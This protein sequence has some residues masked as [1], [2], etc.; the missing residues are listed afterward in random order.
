MQSRDFK[1]PISVDYLLNHCINFT[2]KYYCVL[3]HDACNLGLH[4]ALVSRMAPISCFY[5]GVYVIVMYMYE[6]RAL[7]LR[8]RQS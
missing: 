5:A 6:G 4:F 8:R 7:F 1:G 2:L 3:C